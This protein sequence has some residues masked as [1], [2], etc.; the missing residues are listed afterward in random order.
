MKLTTA[1]RESVLGKGSYAS[2][3]WAANAGVFKQGGIPCVLFG[4]GSIAQAHTKN[5]FIDMQQVV[6]AAE[7]FAEVIRGAGEGLRRAG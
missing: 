3:P 6:K 7:F 4:P 2:A 5:E 1:A